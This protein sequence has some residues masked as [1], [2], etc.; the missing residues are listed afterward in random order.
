MLRNGK[1]FLLRH[2]EKCNLYQYFASVLL[3]VLLLLYCP[4]HILNFDTGFMRENCK[5]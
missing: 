1:H 3:L 2:I 4:W 5:K